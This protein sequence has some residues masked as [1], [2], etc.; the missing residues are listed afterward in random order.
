LSEAGSLAGRV[1]DSVLP[2]V[3]ADWPDPARS[4]LDGA[5]SDLRAARDDAASAVRSAHE[6]ARILRDLL[7]EG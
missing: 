4:I 3:P 5:H 7:R 2:L 1:P 6:I